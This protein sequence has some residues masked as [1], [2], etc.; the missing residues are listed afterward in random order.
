MR[1]LIIITPLF[2][3]APALAQIQAQPRS[4]SS[5]AATVTLTATENIQVSM[6]GAT[7]IDGT[8]RSYERSGQ[9]RGI[10]FGIQS[11]CRHNSNL[12]A[13][14]S[15]I[16]SIPFKAEGSSP[17]YALTMEFETPDRSQMFGCR[18]FTVSLDGLR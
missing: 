10:T 1:A 17:P 3:A 15:L 16:V 8:G 7:L 9:P 12:T 2:M 14:S 11:S 18:A 4:V 13:G 6:I 5:T